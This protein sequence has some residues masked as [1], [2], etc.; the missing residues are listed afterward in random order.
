MATLETSSHA[1]CLQLHCYFANAVPTAF[2]YTF[3]TFLCLEEIKNVQ[4]CIDVGTASIAVID[5]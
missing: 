2:T 5:V 3:Y 1:N 4:L